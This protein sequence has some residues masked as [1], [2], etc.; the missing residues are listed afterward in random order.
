MLRQITELVP[1]G[2]DTKSKNIAVTYIANVGYVGDGLY[3]YMVGYFSQTT[4]PRF[5]YLYFDRKQDVF[6]LLTSFYKFNDYNWR[7]YKDITKMYP[8]HL[9]VISI[10]IERAKEDLK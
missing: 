8:E 5:F 7:N 3:S 4:E 2:D 9:G 1:F 10:F 6:N